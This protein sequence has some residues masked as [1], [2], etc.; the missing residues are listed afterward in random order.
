[1]N[2]S[3]SEKILVFKVLYTNFS[4]DF[5]HK[6]GMKDQPLNYFA[7]A[8]VFRRFRKIVKTIS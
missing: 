2:L 3:P 6:F 5:F 4:V 1:M 7:Y 8:G